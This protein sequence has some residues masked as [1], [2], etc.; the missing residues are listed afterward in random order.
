M[1][2][3]EKNF[4]IW[5]TD[6][7]TE[8]GWVIEKDGEE[9]GIL[10]DPRPDE[11]FYTSYKMEITTNDD[12]LAFR[13][14]TRAFWEKAA[15]HGIKWRNLGFDAVVDDAYPATNPFPEPGRLSIRAL[16]IP[17]REPKFFEKI[18][19]WLRRRKLARQ[20]RAELKRRYAG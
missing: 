11:M 5:E 6:F 17:L 12:D 2:D 8:C 7:G 1:S 4:R 18:T 3:S 14:E 10:S 13:M 19:V 20:K 9:I 16:R 15:E